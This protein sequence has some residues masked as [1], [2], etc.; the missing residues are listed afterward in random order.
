VT[1]RLGS[2]PAQGSITVFVQLASAK[3]ICQRCRVSP[4]CLRYALVTGQRHG[5]WG[6]KSEEERQVLRHQL[7]AGAPVLPLRPAAAARA[8]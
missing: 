1:D 6:G 5:V 3:A 8:G 7:P 4:E 2:F